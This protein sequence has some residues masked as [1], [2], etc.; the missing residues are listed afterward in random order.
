MPGLPNRASASLSAS[1]QNP[2]VSVFDSRQ[3]STRRVAQSMI[4]TRYKNPCCTLRQLPIPPL[5]RGQALVR[6]VDRLAA[7]KI[8]ID[9]VLGMPLAG[10]P[11]RPDR[12]Q[13]ELFHQPPDAPAANQ[14]PLSQQRHLEPPAAVYWTV[15]E[16]PVEPLQKLEF[17]HTLRPRP[18]IKAAA[19]NPEQRALPAYGQPRFRRDHRPPLSTREMAG[20][21]A[22]KSHSTCSWPIFRCRSSIT[23]CASSAPGALLPR[24]NSSVAR[25]TSSCFQLLIIVG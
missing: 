20:C 25:F 14:N 17:L 7:Q 13:P 11:F 12:P 18:V 6:L 23:F 16:N 24:A 9:L 15:C 1:T 22:R 3:D 19:R 8:W 2:A 4:A 5:S 21:P 10:V